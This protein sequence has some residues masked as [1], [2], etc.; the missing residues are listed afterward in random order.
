MNRQLLLQTWRGTAPL[1]VWAAHFAFC[2][3]LVAAQCSP[4]LFDGTAPRRWVLLAACA[5]ALG[6]CAWMLWRA[7]RPLGE[8]ASLREWAAALSALL[9]LAGVA[10]T[11]LPVLML[12]GCA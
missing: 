6:A 4:A 11:S 2:Y 5:L 3:V 8:A 9:A 10:W 12:D 1:L 7:A